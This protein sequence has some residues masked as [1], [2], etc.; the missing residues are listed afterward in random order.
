MTKT[1]Q[2][3][4]FIYSTV[5]CLFSLPGTGSD[6]TI[7]DK[8]IPKSLAA[9]SA[10]SFSTGMRTPIRAHADRRRR[11]SKPHTAGEQ[12]VESRLRQWV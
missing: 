7:N 9:H 3:N 8:G 10:T 1:C 5:T 6:R 11:E 4:V 12:M 2:F